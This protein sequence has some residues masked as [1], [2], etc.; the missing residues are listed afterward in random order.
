VTQAA[1]LVAKQSATWTVEEPE[2]L[3]KMCQANA[4]IEHAYS[5]A[6]TFGQLVR[7]RRCQEFGCWIESTKATG[8]RELKHFAAGL[9]H[10]KA[11]VIAALSLPWSEG[12]V[13]G[14]VHPLK[15]ILYQMHGRASF[16]LLRRRMPSDTG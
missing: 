5:L 14:Y 4:D 6:Q 8:I 1:W 10:D 13:A 15:L 7:E 9:L 11:A 16:D 2:A 12:Q 3:A